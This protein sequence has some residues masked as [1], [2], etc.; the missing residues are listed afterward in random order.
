MLHVTHYIRIE[1][2]GKFLV[3]TFCAK[4]LRDYFLS[5]KLMTQVAL[6]LNNRGARLPINLADNNTVLSQRKNPFSRHYSNSI[7]GQ[8][9][10]Y[11]HFILMSFED[12][13]S[14]VI[15]LPPHTCVTQM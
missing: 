15:F 3:G 14:W 1:A 5:P 11:K 6:E 8:L 9:F 2:M 4:G 12:A 13:A 10:P 7:Y